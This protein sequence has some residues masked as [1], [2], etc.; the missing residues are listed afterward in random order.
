MEKKSFDIGEDEALQQ[1]T[2]LVDEDSIPQ[3]IV[4]DETETEVKPQPVE[5]SAWTNAAS[6]VKYCA[7]ASRLAPQIQATSPTSL[8]RAIAYYDNLEKEIIEGAA[9]DAERAELTIEQL[10]TLDEV[11]DEAEMVRGQLRAAAGRVKM[12]KTAAKAARFVYTVDPFLFAV[13]RLIVN[14]KVSN[15]K[16][17][18]DTFAKVSA[19]YGITDREVFAL[20]QLISDMGYPVHGSFVA[21]DGAYDMIT[22][23]F[24]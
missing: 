14:A 10:Q 5:V 11:S 22:Q 2:I 12:L 4:V 15:G 1:D 9:S 8:T 18:E 6:F 20:R 21:D 3:P 16:N 13:A 19:K 23:Y 17:I 24:A 7:Q